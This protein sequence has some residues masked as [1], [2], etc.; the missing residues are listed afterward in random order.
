M[1]CSSSANN[2]N[3]YIFVGSF[4]AG[5]NSMDQW[6]IREAYKMEVEDLDGR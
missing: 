3:P 6:R 2:F 4:F 5:S 1:S